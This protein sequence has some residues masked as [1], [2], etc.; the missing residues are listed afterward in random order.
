MLILLILLVISLSCSSHQYMTR[1][2]WGQ[3][4]P[5]FSWIPDGGH[6]RSHHGERDSTD[7]LARP[8]WELTP[9]GWFGV[10]RKI[11]KRIISMTFSIFF[12]SFFLW[13]SQSFPLLA[14]FSP[15]CLVF[16]HGLPRFPCGKSRP[17]QD[18]VGKRTPRRC[19]SR[20]SSTQLQWKSTN[21]PGPGPA[22]LGVDMVI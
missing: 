4:L 9:F 3:G 11:T 1:G 19:F 8:R 10:V 2:K 13:F 6:G 17:F 5:V 21:P 16:F 22:W 18:V 15:G 12:F 7:P 20:A 14:W